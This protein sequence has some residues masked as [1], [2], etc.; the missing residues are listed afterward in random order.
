MTRRERHGMKRWWG[1]M[2]CGVLVFLAGALPFVICVEFDLINLDDY[3]YVEHH[4]EIMAGLGWAGLKFAFTSIEEAIWMPL[5]WI[6]YMIDRSLF[7]TAWGWYHLH[8][9]ALHGVNAVLVWRLLSLVFRKVSKDAEGGFRGAEALAVLGA[10]LWAVHPL[11]CESVAWI[12]S[13][14][15]VLSMMWLLAALIL[16]M[17]AG[18]FRRLEHADDGNAK[19]WSCVNVRYGLSLACF[20]LGAMAKPS[21]M[22][23]PVLCFLLDYLIVRRVRPLAYVAPLALAGALGWFA[24][25]AQASGGATENI[26]GMPFWYRLVNAGTA[27]GLYL[28]NMVWPVNLAPQ[29]VIRWPGWPRMCVPGLAICG[30]VAWWLWRSAMRHWRGFEENVEVVWHGGFVPEWRV[31]LAPEPVLAGVAWFALAI[32]PM[33]GIAG[34][35]YHSMADRFTYI[36]AVGLSLMLAGLCRADLRLRRP[37]KLWIAAAGLV[38]VVGLAGMSVRQTGFWRDDRTLF[39]HTL[40]IDGDGNAPAH[41]VLA[42]W[43][44]EFPHDL[45]KCVEHFEK[46]MAS[47]LRFTEASMEIYVFALCELGRE[48]EVP[49]LLKKFDAWILKDSESNPKFGKDSLRT[50]LMRAAYFY[51][52]VAYLVTQPDLRKAAK[53]EM[54]DTPY[55]K[56]EPCLL[57]LKWRLALAEG[58]GERAEQALRDL[59]NNAAPKGYN[60]FAYLR[61]NTKGG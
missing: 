46:A 49:A 22:T 50:K 55:P 52:R 10:V 13:R 51:A 20:M 5:T 11:R 23:F 7:G 32:A 48:K 34:F 12:A 2:A 45:E 28:W 26:F 19:S 35:G 17:K 37:A 9:V 27:F 43:Y 14:K 61:K 42:N 56:D 29:C 47:N 15:D 44:F 30:C 41:G 8:N 1:H 40:A 24:G 39:A 60:R 16:W 6:S 57:Y 33:L 36:P 4:D 54:D 3:W 21:V 18:E 31:R 58:G 38:A 53:E 25:Y 59:L